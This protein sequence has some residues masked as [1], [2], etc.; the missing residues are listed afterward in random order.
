MFTWCSF[1][2]QT[3][4]I[5]FGG[6]GT[7]N[8][9]GCNHHRPP[10]GLHVSSASL[11]SRISSAPMCRSWWPAC[12]TTQKSSVCPWC[13]LTMV[14][15][16]WFVSNVF[17]FHP[18]NWGYDPIWRAYFSNG[19]KPPIS[20][21]ILANFI[22]FWWYFEGFEGFVTFVKRCLIHFWFWFLTNLGVWCSCLLSTTKVCV[23]EFCTT[24]TRDPTKGTSSNS[25][26]STRWHPTSERAFGKIAWSFACFDLTGWLRSANSILPTSWFS[27][28]QSVTVTLP[29]TTFTWRIFWLTRGWQRYTRIGQSCHPGIQQRFFQR[30][31]K[32]PGMWL[33]RSQGIVQKVAAMHVYP[34]P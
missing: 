19:L 30:K 15:F 1:F 33:N 11:K 27:A 10:W 29:S 22:F 7:K 12:D 3:S 25:L 4:H 14:T 8:H 24:T 2:I 26:S 13:E 6:F 28:G 21:F 5:C 34:E 9:G 17:Y 18:E 31:N 23:F 16:R 20:D 32:K